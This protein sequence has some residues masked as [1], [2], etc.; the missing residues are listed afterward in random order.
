M[1]AKARPM[2]V[3]DWPGFVLKAQLLEGGRGKRGLVRRVRQAGRFSRRPP[4]DPAGARR[5]Q[6]PAA[7]RGS[8][9]DRPRNLCRGAHRRQR[10]TARTAGRA[11]RRR[12]CRSNRQ[13]RAHPDRARRADDPG[14]DLCRARQ[15]VSGRSCR[16]PGA[17]RRAA[18]GHRTP[19]GPGIAGDQSAGAD[20]GRQAHR[21]RRQDRPRRRRRFPPRPGTNSRSAGR[22]PSTP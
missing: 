10:A 20:Q 19:G 16:A 18:A 17:L 21:L 12:E 2:T 5:C 3:A 7:A 1:P 22:W 15:A 4:A 14:K 9:A 6:Y 13:A 11:R 8:G